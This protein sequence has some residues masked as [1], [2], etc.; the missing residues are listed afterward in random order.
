MTKEVL[1]GE[2]AS[3]ALADDAIKVAT[4]MSGLIGKRPLL[5]E[6]QPTGYR[7]VGKW[8]NGATGKSEAKVSGEVGAFA[9][10][11]NDGRSFA[12]EKGR[13]R[14]Y[15]EKHNMKPASGKRVRAKKK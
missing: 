8:A 12:S 2:Y 11:Y 13:R 10:K 1:I 7:V 5:F 9:C 4:G 14:H 15:T 6:V 3:Q